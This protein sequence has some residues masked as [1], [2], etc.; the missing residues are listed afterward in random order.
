MKSLSHYTEDGITEAMR[1]HGA[2]FA[3]SNTQL[4]EKE[5][6]G[7]VYVSMGAGLICP[8]LNS[9]AL[10]SD[11]AKIQKDGI[12]QHIKENGKEAIIRHELYNHECFYTGDYH[13]CFDALQGYGFTDEDVK[14]IYN[15]EYV[16]A[17]EA[18]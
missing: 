7:V 13:G 11:M 18:M 3:F 12:K 5:V 4:H 15:A 9:D 16:N 17:A 8:K 1:R 6:E 2:F 10:A 14:K